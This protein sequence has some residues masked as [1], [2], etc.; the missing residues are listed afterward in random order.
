MS[1]GGIS[2]ASQF[3]KI[4]S[5]CRYDARKRQLPF[6]SKHLNFFN[7]YIRQIIK[8]IIPSKLISIYRH[9]KEII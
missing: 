6:Y 8:S 2:N 1:D 7:L 9:N 4:L 5:D 3:R